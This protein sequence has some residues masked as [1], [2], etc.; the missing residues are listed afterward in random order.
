M[1]LPNVCQPEQDW[2]CVNDTS[3]FGHYYSFAFPSLLF[4]SPNFFFLPWL[5]AYPQTPP[6][7][8]LAKWL[9]LHRLKLPCQLLKGRRGHH[10][11][12]HPEG[13]AAVPGPQY[14]HMLS[15]FGEWL[16]AF[17]TDCSYAWLLFFL[18]EV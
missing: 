18:I 10:C 5:Q 13:P 7:F 3:L 1:F 12:I 6:I 14:V 2:D 16:N 4:P 15:M 8:T 9:L 17:P 11:L